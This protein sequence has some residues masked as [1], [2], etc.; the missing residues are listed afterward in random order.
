MREAGCEPIFDM[1]AHAAMLLGAAR[2]ARQAG[3]MLTAAYQCLQNGRL[4]AAVVIDSPMLHLPLALL[5]KDAGVPVLYYVAPQLWAWG[6]KRIEKLRKRVDRLAVILPFEEPYFRERGVEATF[7]GHPLADVLERPPPDAHAVESL[8]RRGQPFIASLPGSRRQVVKQ[9]L[10]DQLDIAERV[11]AAFPDAAFGV[12]IAHDSMGEWVEARARRCAAN[13]QC[14]RGALGNLIEAADLAL[15]ASGTTTLEV[16]FRR[17]PMIVMYKTSRTMAKLAGRWV[18]TPYLALP[19]ILA[20]REIVPEFMPAYASVE[21]IAAR[22]IQLLSSPDDRADMVRALDAA[23]TPL[24]NPGAS[25]RTAQMLFEL[26]DAT[27]AAAH[28]SRA[29]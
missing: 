16:A 28:P 3:G 7:V 17:R 2:A 29:F 10:D 5:A 8:R 27:H 19:N 12:S 14:H 22:A 25:K 4:D 21:P 20:G 24:R 23:V 18:R 9:L 6:E 11:A 1:S 26:I 13:A 15:V